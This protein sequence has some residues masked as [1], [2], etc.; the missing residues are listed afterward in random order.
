MT[1]WT[2]SHQALLSVEFPWQEYQSGLPFKKVTTSYYIHDLPTHL[3]S[4]FNVRSTILG[5]RQ[6]KIKNTWALFLRSSG[7]C[8]S[9][10][11]PAIVKEDS[12]TALSFL[13]YLWMFSL[14]CTSRCHCSIGQLTDQL[15]QRQGIQFFF[16]S[17]FMRYIHKSLHADFSCRFLS[18]TDTDIELP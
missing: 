11:Q 8:S 16:W 6:S 14:T 4:I 18:L 3:W 9:C 13:N 17:W 2:V 5:T 12:K 1:P 7:W 10:Y 15:P